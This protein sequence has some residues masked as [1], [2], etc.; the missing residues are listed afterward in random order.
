[1]RILKMAI[2]NATEAYIEE[3]ISEGINIIYSDENNKGKTIV[4]QS[5]MY[6]LGNRPIFPDSFS[7]KD[8][9]HFIEI[10]NEGRIYEIA[11]I[12]DSFIVRTDN[13]IRIFDGVSEFKRYWNSSIFELPTIMMNGSKKIVDME[14]FIQMFFVGQDGKDTSTIFNPGYYH[15][16]DFKNMVLSYAGTYEAELSAEDVKKIKA[17]IAK[18]SS[19]RTEKMMMNEF[20]QSSSAATEYLSRIKDKDAF[21]ERVQEMDAI[22]ESI[23][24]VRK[25]R[26]RIASQRSL[27]NG[28]LKEL[29][30][31]NRN[32]EVGELRCMDCN[33]THIAYRGTG[34][35]TYSFDVSTPEMRDQIIASILDRIAAYDEEIQRCDFEINELQKELQQLMDDEEVTIENVVA[36]KQGFRSIEEIEGA[37]VQLDLQIAEVEEKLSSGL[38]EAQ[39]ATRE[40]KQFYDDLLDVFNE[41][42]EAIDPDG[43]VIY[44]DIFT[45]RGTVASGSEE[46]VFYV[47]RLL[48]IA[49]KTK[50]PCPIIMDSFRAEDLSTEKEKRVLEL[51]R[52][53]GRQCIL[54]TTLKAEEYGKYSHIDDIHTVDYTSHKSNK[55]LSESYMPAFRTIIGALQ[56]QI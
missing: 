23:A 52:G 47:S 13:E 18:L 55:L 32:I 53:T 43:D 36:Y 42:R 6:A 27:W 33:S 40:R 20:Y 41:A 56:V 35:T 10:E 48:A 28:T 15:K 37:I 46:T 19:Q 45:K 54:T 25:R 16:D 29:R 3:N 44:S 24:E 7:Y 30:S 49:E 12:G 50:H 1:M 14:L 8:Y 11:R 21:Q 22:G 34:K 4:I 17:Q 51:L 26:S 38:N 2:G 5:M 39:T 9:C 31:L